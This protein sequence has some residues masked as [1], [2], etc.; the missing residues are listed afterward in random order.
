MNIYDKDRIE[1]LE[2]NRREVE[3]ES[4]EELYRKYF[5]KCDNCGLTD[6]INRVHEVDR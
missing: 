4:S 6:E 3:Y 2:K 5:K 1:R